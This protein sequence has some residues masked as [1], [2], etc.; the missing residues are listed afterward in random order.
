MLIT[1]DKHAIKI[2]SVA[3]LTDLGTKDC[4]AASLEAMILRKNFNI[5]VIHMSHA[6]P[7]GSVSTAAMFLEVDY[8][9]YLKG[10][11]FVAIVDS[12]AC[13]NSRIIFVWCD[14]YY[15]IGPDNG[16]FTRVFE[17]IRPHQI[18][19]LNKKRFHSE[20]ISNM[21]ISAAVLSNRFLLSDL[22]EDIPEDSIVKLD[23]FAVIQN[24]KLVTKVLCINNRGDL[25]TG[26]TEKEF[27]R[28]TNGNSFGI[29]IN[30]EYLDGF[31]RSFAELSEHVPR[32]LFNGNFSRYGTI[33][34]KKDSAKNFIG[35]DMGT[36][37]AI[38]NVERMKMSTE[39][40]N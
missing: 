40:M 16:V 17:R 39:H 30:S 35:A 19:E 20:N 1:T 12:E 10:T 29:I 38:F 13:E 23:P 9:N 32:L 22:G 21:I 31:A 15:F 24:G 5:R 27:K 28:F 7:S 33:A 11:A 25:V 4:S 18:I 2:H 36:E 8:R 14:G 6:V 3:L 26:L 37:V 34:M